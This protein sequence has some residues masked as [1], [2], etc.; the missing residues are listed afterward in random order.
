MIREIG[1]GGAETDVARTAGVGTTIRLKRRR[2][3]TTRIARPAGEELLTRQRRT[4]A[5]TSIR[6]TGKS[7]RT[8]W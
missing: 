6:A 2:P 8:S 7:C 3:A 1:A 5:R 4:V